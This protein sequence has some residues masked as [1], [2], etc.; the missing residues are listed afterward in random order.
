MAAGGRISVR[1]G[2]DGRRFVELIT[3]SDDEEGAGPSR[4]RAAPVPGVKVKKEDEEHEEEEEEEAAYAGAV[5]AAGDGPGR[6][7]CPRSYRA[8]Y[9]AGGRAG[10]GVGDGASRAKTMTRFVGEK[11]G[12]WEDWRWAQ[13]VSEAMQRYFCVKVGLVVKYSWMS[14]GVL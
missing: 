9:D 11:G 8:W 4:G 2:H 14:D 3:L 6:P 7:R 10:Y 5:H 12:E 13:V 1:D